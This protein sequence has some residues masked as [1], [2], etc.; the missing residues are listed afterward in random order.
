M[1]SCVE[2]FRSRAWLR[3]ATLTFIAGAAAGCSADTSRFNE[4]PFGVA[5][6]HHSGDVTGSVPAAQAAPVGRVETKPLAQGSVPLPPPP[7]PAAVASKP[8]PVVQAPRPAAPQPA[9]SW[10]GGTAIMVVPGDTLVSLSHKYNVPASAIVQANGL[11]PNVALRVGQRVVI[12]R[13]QQAAAAPVAPASRPAPMV[14]QQP[15]PVPA[16]LASVPA[17]GGQTHIVAPGENLIKIASHYHVSLVDLAKANKIPPHTKLNLGDRLVIPGGHG[18]VAA[19]APAIPAQPRQAPVENQKV[20]AAE[21]VNARVFTPATETP[22]AEPAVKAAEATGSMPG[23]RWP[24]RGRV[25]AGFGPKP[26][27]QQNDGINL[28]LPEGTPVK[29]AEDGV[30]AY[31]G[32]E[33]KGYGN[34]VLV[35]HANGYVTAYAHASELLVKRNDPV[36]R[37]QVIARSGQTGTVSSP[38]LHFEIR[39]GSA[40]VDPAPFLDRG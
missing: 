2:L 33:L 13:H 3:W 18:Q 6:A 7:Q 16:K 31:A 8:T 32:N 10:N 36:K 39:K 29:A 24:V 4:N 28:A 20:A 11:Q 34:L 40:P 21:P 9:W 5:S 12:P 19:A 14:A 25:I 15:A 22:A 17:V 1:Q 30:V 23:F 37:G 27:G 38:Q 35:R 26:N